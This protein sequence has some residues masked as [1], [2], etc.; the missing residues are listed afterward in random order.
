MKYIQA[1]VKYNTF[2]LPSLLLSFA[3]P[4]L[5]LLDKWEELLKEDG[6]R[7][8]TSGLSHSS[9]QPITKHKGKKELGP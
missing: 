9:V 5:W 7:L 8:D 2:F 6:G 1:V 3:K 4:A